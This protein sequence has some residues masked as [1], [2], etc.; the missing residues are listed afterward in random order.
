M[1]EREF[2]SYEQYEGEI[3]AINPKTKEKIYFVAMILQI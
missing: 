3:I 2:T 1:A